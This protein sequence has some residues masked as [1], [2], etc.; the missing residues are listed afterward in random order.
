MGCAFDFVCRGGGMPRPLEFHTQK[1]RGAK[2]SPGG[3]A[4]ATL[5]ATD[6]VEAKNLRY[7]LVQNCYL[8]PH[9][10]RLEPDHLPLQGKAFSVPSGLTSIFPLKYP[11]LTGGACRRPY[12]ASPGHFA[13]LLKKRTSCRRG[14][15]LRQRKYFSKIYSMVQSCTFQKIPTPWWPMTVSAEMPWRVDLAT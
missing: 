12:N 5:V 14:G 2:A 6:E 3:K 15:P 11:R 4:G 7:K 10:V 9:P 13:S 8:R 1:W